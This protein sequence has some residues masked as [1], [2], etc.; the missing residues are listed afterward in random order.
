MR[1]LVEIIP[2]HIARGIIIVG[3]PRGWLGGYGR[4]AVLCRS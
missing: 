3:G 4:F 1:P 2:C